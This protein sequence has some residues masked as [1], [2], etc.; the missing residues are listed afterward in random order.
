MLLLPGLVIGDLNSV[1]GLLFILSLAQGNGQA[2][3][4]VGTGNIGPVAVAAFVVVLVLLQQY[5]VVP[6]KEG[7]KLNRWQVLPFNDGD[8]GHDFLFSHLQ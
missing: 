6:K 2:Q 5:P 8:S 4:A 7:E 1:D 3:G